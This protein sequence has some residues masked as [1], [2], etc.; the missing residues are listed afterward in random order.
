[1]SN[2]KELQEFTAMMIRL[3]AAYRLLPNK[4]AT[5]AVNFS[6]ERFRQQNWLGNTTQPWK[7]RKKEGKRDR[8]RAILVKTGNLKR[9]VH[10]ISVTATTALIGTSKLTGGYAKAHNEGYRG[11]VT[12]KSHKRHVYSKVKEK[13]T[14]RNGKERSR[15]RK[16]I[17]STT[18]AG[19]V[20]SHKRRMNLVMRKFLGASPVMDKQINR[21]MAAEL[22]RA[23]KG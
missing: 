16:T 22:I 3:E 23:I 4:A 20:R 21:M 2:T 11:T 9:D 17:D 10:K 19:T 6:K 12:V 8:G 14:T 13:Y 1:M 18:P 5:V 7:K 15:T